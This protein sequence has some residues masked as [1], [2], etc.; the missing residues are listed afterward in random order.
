MA[1]KGFRVE[2]CIFPAALNVLVWPLSRAKVRNS[3][4]TWKVF[5]LL[6]CDSAQRL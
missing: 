5:F 6:S 2:M 3:G 1:R 4:K